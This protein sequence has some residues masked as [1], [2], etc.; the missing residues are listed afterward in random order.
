MEFYQHQKIACELETKIYFCD[1]YS[2][3]QKG[4]VENVNKMVREYLPK[5][6][7]HPNISHDKIKNIENIINLY[8]RKC[9]NFKSA[10][11]TFYNKSV[12]ITR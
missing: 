6:E 2:S 4:T 5:N 8:P 7:S 12:A 11:E 10:S 3:W 1:P 9:L